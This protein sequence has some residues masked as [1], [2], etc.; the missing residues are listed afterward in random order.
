MKQGTLAEK[1]AGFRIHAFVFVPSL[2]LLAVIN[3]LTGPPWW[4][5][6]VVPPWAV[7]LFAHWF[8]VLGPGAMKGDHDAPGVHRPSRHKG[9]T[10]P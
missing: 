1:R 8:F 4:F 2:A 6:W 9:G 5:L 10:R 3:L 7:G